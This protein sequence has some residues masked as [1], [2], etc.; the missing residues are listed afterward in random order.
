[1]WLRVHE[2]VTTDV[3]SDGGLNV[4]ANLSLVWYINVA[5]ISRHVRT[6]WTRSEYSRRS[7]VIG[8]TGV[9]HCNDRGGATRAS[10]LL[11]DGSSWQSIV[12]SV[13]DK[14][15]SC[16]RVHTISTKFR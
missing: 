1:M 7:D 13:M 15:F 11:L 2:S 16:A 4:V 6:L 8:L 12:A 14:R 10:G 9:A 5:G 3:S